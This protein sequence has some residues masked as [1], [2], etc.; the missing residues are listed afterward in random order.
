M[1]RPYQEILQVMPADL[2]NE[3]INYGDRGK[4]D[5]HIVI[6]SVAFNVLERASLYI[7]VMYAV[8]L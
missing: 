1:N 7:Y 6:S 8:E 5:D 4:I 2:P 3:G